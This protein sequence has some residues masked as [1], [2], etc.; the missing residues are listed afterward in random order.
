MRAQSQQICLNE[1]VWCNTFFKK[2]QLGL[3]IFFL[4]KPHVLQHRWFCNKIYLKQRDMVS[5]T[6]LDFLK[7]HYNFLKSM[8]SWS[9]LNKASFITIFI[10]SCRILI[11]SYFFS[12]KS[13][14]LPLKSRKIKTEKGSSMFIKKTLLFGTL[15]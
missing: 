13:N 12:S 11:V 1:T 5:F 6:K 14:M 10:H 3:C 8:N 15:I 9:K 4:T 7:E 2:I